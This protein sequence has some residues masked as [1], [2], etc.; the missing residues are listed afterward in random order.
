M[1]HFVNVILHNIYIVNDSRESRPGTC[2]MV[3]KVFNCVDIKSSVIA[4]IKIHFH[5]V[6]PRITATLVIR[7]LRYYS[8]FLLAVWQKPQY[9]FL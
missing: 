2:S 7:S 8:H 5:T 6:K 1:F 9:I 4:F 3:L